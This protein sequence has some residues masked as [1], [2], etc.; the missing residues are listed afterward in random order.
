MVNL[1]RKFYQN[2]DFSTPRNHLKW[3][4]I[5]LQ[6]NDIADLLGIYNILGSLQAK[7]FT[8]EIGNFRETGSNAETGTYTHEDTLC[9]YNT[10]AKLVIKE[11]IAHN[12]CIGCSTG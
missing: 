4:D 6:C 3:L 1:S 2:L 9:T 12:I 8:S 10:L 7:D 11:L 5:H